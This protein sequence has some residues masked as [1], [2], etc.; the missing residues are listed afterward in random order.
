MKIKHYL[1]NTFIIESGKSKVA[2]DPGQYLYIF[3]LKSL[4]PK[5]EW[6]DIT[7]I[8][9]T[10]GDPDHHW[11]SDRVAEASGAHVICGKEMTRIEN[12]KI[13][14]VA[15][16]GKELTSWVSFENAHPMEVGDVINLDDVEIEA[17]KSV[18][19]PIQI[20][21]YGFKKIQYPG[22]N[23]RVGL[24]SMGFKINFDGKM[25]LN[26]ADSLLLEDW[27][28]L[29]PDVLMLP[30]GGL[31]NNMWTMDL[32][33]ALQAVKSISPKLVIPCH[34]SVPFLWS[35]KYCPADDQ[36]FKSEVENMGFECRIMKYGDEIDL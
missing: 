17:V 15:P 21:I 11:Q 35:K 1:Y 19:G 29:R 12:G 24:G 22:P 14:L 30:I 32:T 2:I 34:Y 5:E 10:H 25:I 36:K 18:H 13:L 23:E 27:E 26:L 20:S 33:D 16:R 7:H 31:G 4:I 8:L 28:G 6:K 3:N 9:I